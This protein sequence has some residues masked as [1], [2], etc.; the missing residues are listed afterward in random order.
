MASVISF[1]LISSI[2]K[3]SVLERIFNFVFCSRLEIFRH[4]FESVSANIHNK[5]IGNWR[6]DIGFGR[7]RFE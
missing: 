1:L 5:R 7:N 2:E 3:I 4:R 6:A